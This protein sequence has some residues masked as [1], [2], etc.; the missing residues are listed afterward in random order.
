MVRETNVGCI[1]KRLVSYAG[2]TVF[3]VLKVFDTLL[4]FV[5]FGGVLVEVF[6]LLLKKIMIHYVLTWPSFGCV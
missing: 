2:R 5:L 6:A 1:S 4:T 3:L